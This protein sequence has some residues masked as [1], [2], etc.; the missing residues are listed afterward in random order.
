MKRGKIIFYALLC[1]AILAYILPWVLNKSSGL[2]VGAYDLAAWANLHPSSRP[3]FIAGWLLRAQLVLITG[4][5][6]FNYSKSERFQALWWFSLSLALLL[7]VAQ[8]PP[9]EFFMHL[10]NDAN[11]RQQALLAGMAFVLAILG[12]TGLVGQYQVYVQIGLASVGIISSWLGFSQGQALMQTYGLPAYTGLGIAL[13]L[14][15][16]GGLLINRMLKR[17]R[18]AS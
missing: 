5:L 2:T 17:N 6:A 12:F 1:L 10:P 7:L 9:F 11:Q 14:G 13:M 4:I 18:T 8:L 3:Y 15:A 16:Y